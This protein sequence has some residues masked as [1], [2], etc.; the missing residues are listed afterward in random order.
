MTKATMAEAR[1]EMWFDE[2]LALGATRSIRL[3]ASEAQRIL[4]GFPPGH[5]A[6]AD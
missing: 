6:P 2:Y 3:L 4:G 5:K 1:S